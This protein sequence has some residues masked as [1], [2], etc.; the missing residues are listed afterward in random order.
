MLEVAE[1]TYYR[2]RKG[3]V[4]VR[5]DWPNPLKAFENGDARLISL[6]AKAVLGDANLREET[7]CYLK[8]EQ[9]TLRP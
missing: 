4:G 7:A 3:Y 8:P 2:G 5:I 9:V 6:L 1:R